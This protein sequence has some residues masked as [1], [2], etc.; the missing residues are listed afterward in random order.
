[1]SFCEPCSSSAFQE[2]LYLS[3]TPK[4]ITVYVSLWPHLFINLIWDRLFTP[5]LRCA[6]IILPTLPSNSR[7]QSVFYSSFMIKILYLYIL[8][9]Y[10]YFLHVPSIHWCIITVN[11]KP[12]A[13]IW[14]IKFYSSMVCLW[15]ETVVW[16]TSSVTHCSYCHAE[17]AGIFEKAW[18]KWEQ[19]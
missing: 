7:I 13:R 14:A 16:W 11:K 4:L 15:T 8:L 1:V 2:I 6:L 10:L 3:W 19:Y 5:I 12:I 9:I 17:V 18:D